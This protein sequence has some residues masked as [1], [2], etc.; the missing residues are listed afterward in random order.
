MPDLPL[1]CAD[2]AGAMPPADRG[3]KPSGIPLTLFHG[4]A[5]AIPM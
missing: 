3:V 2:Y 1:T 4:E 5:S